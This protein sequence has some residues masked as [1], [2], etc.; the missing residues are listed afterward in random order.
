MIAKLFIGP[1]ICNYQFDAFDSWCLRESEIQV[2]GNQTFFSSRRFAT[3]LRRFL[4]LSRLKKNLWDQGIVLER[5]RLILSALL[6]SRLVSLLRFRAL[7]SFVL[8]IL[9]LQDLCHDAL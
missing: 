2:Q 4:A 8:F 9:S 1:F 6:S 3:R 7:C 5:L